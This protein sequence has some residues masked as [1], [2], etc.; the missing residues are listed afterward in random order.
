MGAQQWVFQSQ[1]AAL[2]QSLSTQLKVSPLLSRLLINRGVKD[3]DAGERFLRPSMERLHDP[4]RMGQVEKAVERVRRAIANKEHIRTQ[5]DYDVDGSTSSALLHQFFGL[6]NANHSFA[7]PSRGEGYGLSHKAVERAKADGVTLMLT[8]DNGIAAHDEIAHA[9][10]L[11]IDVIVTDHHPVGERLP[12]AYAIVHPALPGYDYPFAGLCGCAVA[13]KFALAIAGSYGDANTLGPRFPAFLESALALVAIASVCDVVALRDENRVLVRHGLAALEVTRHPGLR[14]L[15]EVSQAGAPITTQEI[16]FR[17]GPRINAGGRLGQESLAATLL[18]ETNDERAKLLAM[19][20]DLLNTQRQKLEREATKKAKELVDEFGGPGEI[21][22]VA[23]ED[24]MPGLAGIVA[25]RLVDAYNRPAVVL[26][27][28]GDGIA[29][30]SGRSVPDFHLLDALKACE[31]H[32]IRYGGHAQ[33]AGVTINK[34]GIDDFR[35]AVNK[36]AASVQRFTSER[37]LL[38]VD[39]LIGGEELTLDFAKELSWL[40]PFGEGNPEPLLALEAGKVIGRPRL[41]GKTGKHLTFHVAPENGQAIRAIG[42][43]LAAH[44]DTLGRSVDLVFAPRIN[45]YGGRE[46]LEIEVRDVI[47]R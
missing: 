26:S 44:L 1:P 46:E 40:E 12:P 17:I 13:F 4:M 7:I 3:A 19:E 38:G 20:M 28:N 16:G 14:A 41:V 8:V 30:G 45:R 47:S 36:A 6:L 37:A 42:F 9:R 10:E 11:G 5:G 25:A 39:A 27:I 24:I 33:A 35:V 43:G 31:S 32:F 29:T 21:V 2:V 23:H 22:V 18:T 15:R 34:S